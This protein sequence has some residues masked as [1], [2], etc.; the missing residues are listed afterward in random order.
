[1]EIVND[2]QAT[3]LVQAKRM[4]KEKWVDLT[5]EEQ[6]E[7]L[8]GYKG[9]ITIFDLNRIGQ[10]VI[11]LQDMITSIYPGN[12]EFIYGT[13]KT[14]WV[15]TNKPTKEEL[16]AISDA[17]RIVTN[18]IPNYEETDIDVFRFCTIDKI[19]HFET[20]MKQCYIVLSDLQEQGEHINTVEWQPSDSAAYQADIK[21][22][23]F[24]L[25]V[26]IPI[27]STLTAT[28]TMENN[29]LNYTHTATDEKTKTYRLP[30]ISYNDNEQWHLEVSSVLNIEEVLVKTMANY[31]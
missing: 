4:I 14:N 31:S 24:P 16:Y 25:E 19:N 6:E 26:V 23:A 22:G 13:P 29:T 30:I 21:C 10:N 17:C 9:S 27:G 8:N 1:M 12:I 5:V 2:R 15:D 20:A 28:A 7:W 3:D 11:T 18:L